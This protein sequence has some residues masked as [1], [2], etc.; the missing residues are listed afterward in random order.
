MA[1]RTYKYLIR[2]DIF[3]LIFNKWTRFREIGFGFLE[4]SL[5]YAFRA[6]TSAFVVFPQVKSF[7]VKARVVGNVNTNISDE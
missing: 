3:M 2:C 6:V 4:I 7:I 5:H 1:F